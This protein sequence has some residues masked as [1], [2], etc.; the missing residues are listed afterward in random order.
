MISAVTCALLRWIWH[1]YNLPCVSVLFWLISIARFVFKS[2]SIY[3]FMTLTVNCERVLLY[4]HSILW[5][6]ARLWLELFAS[7]VGRFLSQI[8]YLSSYV[9]L[10]R[11][12]SFT[13]R[14]LQA[15]LEKFLCLLHWAIWSSLC[16]WS[17][18]YRFISPLI[19]LV[20]QDLNVTHIYAQAV[21]RVV[22]VIVHC[23]CHCTA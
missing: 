9:F 8:S 20:P 17:L 1:L 11:C 13:S 4:S 14:K 6:W 23:I 15:Y 16:P 12:R 18:M 19:V 2:P 22:Y 21:L 10:R 5:R 7:T 3:F